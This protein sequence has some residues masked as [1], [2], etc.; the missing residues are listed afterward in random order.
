MIFKFKNYKE[1]Q[2]K[3]FFTFHIINLYYDFKYVEGFADDLLIIETKDNYYDNF[4]KLLFG[5]Y[6]DNEFVRCYDC[7]KLIH[8][9]NSITSTDSYKY[10]CEDC[11]TQNNYNNAIDKI[12]SFEFSDNGEEIEQ[13]LVEDHKEENKKI[14]LQCP[15]LSRGIFIT[16]SLF[17]D[18]LNHTKKFF[19]CDLDT[20][21]N[22]LKSIKISELRCIIYNTNHLEVFERIYKYIDEVIEKESYI[23]IERNV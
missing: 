2:H 7:H 22:E 9:S 8:K 16:E 19:N 14:L 13:R 15:E 1:I 17:M 20:L 4:I 18:F 10:Y 5:E 21:I 3:L 6:I 23:N 12:K 11:F